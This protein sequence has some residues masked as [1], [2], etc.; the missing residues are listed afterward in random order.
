VICIFSTHKYRLGEECIENSP[1]E[2][3]L[4]VQLHEK[5]DMSQLCVLAAPSTEG[6]QQG[7]G[8]DCPPL[9]C[10]CEAPPAVLH[11]GLGTSMRRM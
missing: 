4:G 9:L 10:P 6:W 8:G 7:E 1:D 11:P 2:K 3:G 5:L